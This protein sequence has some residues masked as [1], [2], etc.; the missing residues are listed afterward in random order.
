MGGFLSEKYASK[1]ATKSWYARVSSKQADEICSNPEQVLVMNRT[2]GE[3]NE[4]FIPPT[5]RMALRTL[6][7]SA[8]GSKGTKHSQPS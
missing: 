8:L 3:V 6:Y 1:K 7:Q 5:I 4:E 2:T